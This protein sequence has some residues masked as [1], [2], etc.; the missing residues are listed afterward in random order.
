MFKLEGS[1][2]DILKLLFFL[3]MMVL[4]FIIRDIIALVFIAVI[5][6]SA[7]N[8][9]VDSLDKRKIPRPISVLGIL[10]ILLVFVYLLFNTLI[11]PLVNETNTLITSIP[12]LL[13]DLVEK[14]SLE[15][16]F[17]NRL[18][19]SNNTL[20]AGFIDIL[21]NNSNNLLKLST[22][23]FN[24]FIQIIT[25]I[26][27]TYYLLVEHGGIQD[28]FGNFFEGASKQK[29]KSLWARVEQKLGVWLRGQIT[30][31]FIIGLA[32]YIGLEILG[33]K[34]ALPLAIIA[35]ILEI[36]PIIGPI[37][38]VIPALV[39]AISSSQSPITVVSVLVLYFIIQQLESVF[40]I[41]RVMQQAV[42]LNPI[43]VILAVMIGSRLGGPL[44][45][46]LSVPVSAILLIA[47]DEWKVVFEKKKITTSQPK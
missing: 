13:T 30:V 43:I 34:F 12:N 19:L 27:L 47:F 36:V 46:L 31:M 24:S 22:G 6:T 17:S 3:L 42:G 18:S 45:A 32:S 10:S 23:I 40:V 25:V 41:P 1:F 35:G 7:L 11:P 9:I 39:I 38:S 20:G 5:L 14:L 21:N 16:F 37:L 2:K 29:F 44:G 15:R 28:F 33:L 4:A 8:P 26:V